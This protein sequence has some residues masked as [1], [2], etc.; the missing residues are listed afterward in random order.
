MSNSNT[1]DGNEP[2]DLVFGPNKLFGIETGSNL[3]DVKVY[4]LF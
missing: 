2:F 3:F 1:G 4:G